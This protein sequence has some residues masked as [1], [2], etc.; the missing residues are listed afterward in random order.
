[1]GKLHDDLAALAGGESRG[2]RKRYGQSR[3]GRRG[4]QVSLHWISSQF[5]F[6]PGAGALRSD[7]ATLPIIQQWP[8]QSAPAAA[9]S[10]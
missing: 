8:C 6:V 4:K 10:G 3:G 5:F 2:G 1:M 7:A 9:R